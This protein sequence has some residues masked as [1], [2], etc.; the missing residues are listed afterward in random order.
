MKTKRKMQ[1]ILLMALLFV[2]IKVLQAG[3]LYSISAG[4][5]K[6][7]DIVSSMRIP[8][9]DKEIT[10]SV[11]VRGK[12]KHPVDVRFTIESPGL[13]K[14]TVWAKPSLVQ[15]KDGSY[16]DYEAVWKP[17]KTGFYDF[18]VVIDPYG[19]SGDSVTSN[20][21]AA[22]LL[23]VTWRNIELI[24]WGPQP[25]CKWVGTSV[26]VGMKG[27][28][29]KKNNA[30]LADDIAYWKRR[31]T[32]TLGYIYC[33]PG[34]QME[35]TA[36]Q[37]IE[38]FVEK[39]DA[40]AEMGCDGLIIDETGSYPDEQGFEFI[41]R[42]GVACDEI[43]KKYPHLQ[44]YNWIGG[45]MHREEVEIARRNA[46]ILLAES[47]ET[48]HHGTYG[49][50]FPNFIS[51]RVERIGNSWD[52]KGLI[53]LGTGRSCG[54][55]FRSH[56]ENNVR[57]CRKLGPELPGIQYYVI[58]PLEEGAPY[59][60]SF[61]EFLDDISIKYFIKPVLMVEENDIWLSNFDPTRKEKVSL[62]VRIHNIGGM[63]AKN[64]KA[65]F[66]ARNM[67][68]NKREVI[69]TIVIPKI[70]NGMRIIEDKNPESIEYKVLDGTKYPVAHWYGKSKVLLNRALADLMWT[71]P[72]AGYYR[73]EVELQHSKQYTVLEGFA[74]RIVTVRD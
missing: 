6:D 26:P 59:K 19:K 13:D 32:R 47:Y 45:P 53:A 36:E 10:L 73:I 70:G 42:F 31:G 7:P 15:D 2:N 56:I 30:V 20:N 40:Y 16:T 8:V 55:E 11:R 46:H 63:A 39:A 64:V 68:T 17:S 18:K 21:S 65:E 71:P 5:I 14:V 72:K 23:P 1:F 9:V 66:Y 50:T 52:H 44:V 48:F 61:Q 69:A 28:G 60:G 37:M 24:P 41:R 49:P 58:R 29:S 27:V 35:K 22:I 62:Q 43:Y 33:R 67:D 74:K 38:Y 57:L 54:R 3:D 34:S 25:Y 51:N 4:T 12:G